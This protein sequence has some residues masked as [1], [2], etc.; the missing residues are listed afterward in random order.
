[1]DEPKD[2]H[3][4]SNYSAPGPSAGAFRQLMIVPAHPTGLNRETS[5]PDAGP[6]LELFYFEP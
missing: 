5:P 4:A 1:M 6:L 3:L 2:V